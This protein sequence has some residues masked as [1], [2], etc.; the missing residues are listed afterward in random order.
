MK[1][2]NEFKFVALEA[3][4]SIP[5]TRPIRIVFTTL[6]PISHVLPNVSERV[7]PKSQPFQKSSKSFPSPLS[8]KFLLRNCFISMGL[9]VWP[10]R[11]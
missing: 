4:G 11:L 1:K 8:Y 9:M 6:N 10:E 3:V 7:V 2:I 5:I